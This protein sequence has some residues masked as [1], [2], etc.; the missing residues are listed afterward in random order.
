M[1]ASRA[2][3][4]VAQVVSSSSAGQ[5]MRVSGMIAQAVTEGSVE[6]IRASQIV[7]QTVGQGTPELLRT[8]QMVAQAVVQNL[9]DSGG[10]FRVTQN[11]AQVV[12]SIGIP[13][14]D[15]QRAW[16]FDFDGH[17]FYV[18]DLGAKGAVVFDTTTQSW[19]RFSTAGYEGH[20]NFKQG[21]H[22]R[23]GK[24]VIGGGILNGLIVKLVEN[25]FLDEDFRPVS[26]EVQG[27]IFETTERH[28]RQFAL[29]VVGSPGRRALD[30]NDDPPTLNMQYS[31]DNGA[32]WSTAMT[33]TLTSD[34]NQ[35]IEFRSLGAFRQPGRIFRLYDS[36][37]IKFLAYVMAD[38]E[39][40]Q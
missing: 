3:Q 31:D 32:T 15:V 18:L 24:A 14:T 39:G 20:W 16:T 29:R 12:F 38:V 10:V 17:T 9:A 33:V 40:E 37:G 28:R 4:I 22:W 1:T 7:A 21:F 36:G 11:V 6:S 19:A 27:V 23:D 2:S 5:T 34:A 8:S 35:R 26:Y 13:D 25:G 30:D